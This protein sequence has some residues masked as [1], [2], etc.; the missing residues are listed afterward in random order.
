MALT[1]TRIV[2]IISQETG[3]TKNQ[4]SHAVET[5]MD[6]MKEPLA[7]GEDFLISGFGKFC[8]KQKSKRCG[9]KP[10]TGDPMILSAPRVVTFKCSGKLRDRCNAEECELYGLIKTRL[11][12]I[13]YFLPPDCKHRDV[14]K[15]LLMLT[16][17]A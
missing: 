8:V 13:F 4:S 16:M 5:L 12:T 17:P 1:K 15:L 7:S 6:L 9:R 2:R 11:E 3:L 14:V 10:A